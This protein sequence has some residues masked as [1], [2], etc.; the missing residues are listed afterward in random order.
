MESNLSCPSP[1]LMID[2]APEAHV[3]ESKKE[4]D[5]FEEHEKLQLS[6]DAPLVSHNFLLTQ[7]DCLFTCVE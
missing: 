4:V 6:D 1:Q 7:L 2:S 3:E 5:F